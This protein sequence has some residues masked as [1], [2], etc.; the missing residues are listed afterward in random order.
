MLVW[1][2]IR[3]VTI[4]ICWK[5]DIYTSRM[6]IGRIGTRFAWKLQVDIG[7]EG[8]YDFEHAIVK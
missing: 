5:R 6:S 2:P 7:N 1:I 4:S 3:I 8:Y